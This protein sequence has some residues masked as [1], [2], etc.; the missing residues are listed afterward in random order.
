MAEGARLLS[1]YGGLTSIAGSNPAFSA[2]SAPASGSEHRVPLRIAH[3]GYPS[4]GGENSLAAI[5]A[6]VAL[7][8]DMVEIDVRRRGDGVLVLQHDRGVRP[9]APTLAAALR[10]IAAS[11]AGVNLDLKEDEVWLEVIEHVRS[12]GLLGRAA[13]TGGGWGT[14]ARIHREEP[15]IRAGLT[16]PRRGGRLPH[17]LRP[18]VAPFVRIRVARAVGPLMASHGVDLVTLHHRLVGRRVVAAVHAAGGEAWCWT[19]NDAGEMAR[20]TA[21]GIDGVCSDV[22]AC[23]GLGAGP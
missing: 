20:V 12:A 17:W 15:G 11:G 7:G 5:G 10:L 3:R 16:L 6:A 9:A 8:C 4:L 19:V 23:H 14:L 18:I 1:G 13:V 21:A 2:L 22:P